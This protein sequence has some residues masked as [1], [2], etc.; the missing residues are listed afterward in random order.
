MKKTALILAALLTGASLSADESA[1]ASSYNVTAD[2]SYATKYVFRG[3][4]YAEGA[5][6]P[7]IKLTTGDFYIGVWSSLPADRGYEAEVDYYAGYGLKLSDSVSLDVGA[8][9]YHYPG[10]D[11]PGADEATFEGYAGIT[12]SVEGVNLG[13]YLYNDFTLDV[14]TV[15]GNL[16][17]SIPVNDTVSL[18]FT[19]SLGHAKPDGGDG[20]TYYSAG[21]ALPYKLSD[22]ASLTLGVNWASHDLDGVEDNHAWANVGFSYTF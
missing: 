1:P 20:Y 22:A 6:Q 16:G 3:I 2:F 5:F 19:A 17:Y 21:L 13:L 7:S 15:Q 9:V 18:S 4:E 11:V 10:L 8:T 12:G 14:V